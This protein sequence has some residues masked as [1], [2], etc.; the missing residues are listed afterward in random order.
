MLMDRLARGVGKLKQLVEDAR[1]AVK[2]RKPVKTV[3]LT[4][5]NELKD[6]S[7]QSRTKA[8][9]EADLRSRGYTPVLA[10]SGEEVWTK[11]MP[12]SNMAIVRVVYT[13][14]NI[15]RVRA[16]NGKALC[17]CLSYTKIYS[18]LNNHYTLI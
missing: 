18:S 4:A 9:I 2:K 12:D 5:A 8:D 6:I 11:P 1:E 16:M 10:H 17:C 13:N 15:V 14:P 3:F 7:L